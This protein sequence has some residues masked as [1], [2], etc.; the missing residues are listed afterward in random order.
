MS[1]P[2][3]TGEGSFEPRKGARETI[4]ARRMSPKKKRESTDIGGTLGI[5]K[6]KLR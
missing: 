3:L 5:L 2:I 4:G 1:N 6:T